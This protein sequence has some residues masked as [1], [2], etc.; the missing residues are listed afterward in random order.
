MARHPAGHVQGA[1]SLRPRVEQIWTVGLAETETRKW[2][3]NV[4]VGASVAGLRDAK[5]K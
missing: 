4:R 1:C 2:A 5:K 3:N